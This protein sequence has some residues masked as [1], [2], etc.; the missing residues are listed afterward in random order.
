[1]GVGPGLFG[2]PIFVYADQRSPFGEDRGSSKVCVARP[3]DL[4][5]DRL[6]DGIELQLGTDPADA[7]SDDD[8]VSDGD[9]VLDLAT[10][11]LSPPGGGP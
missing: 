2:L 4:D 10:D 7:D 5:G 6:P 3:A 11:P 1:M 8:G 9:E